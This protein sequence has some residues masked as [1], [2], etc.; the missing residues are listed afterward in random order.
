M[1]RAIKKMVK[2]RP[3]LWVTAIRYTFL[4]EIFKGYVL[5]LLPCISCGQYVFSSFML[6]FFTILPRGL[7]DHYTFIQQKDHLLNLSTPFEAD[8]NY[9]SIS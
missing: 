3:L 9:E 6:N 4:P 8:T 5:A 7:S 1:L 2:R